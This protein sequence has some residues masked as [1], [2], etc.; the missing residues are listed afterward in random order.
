MLIA[1]PLALEGSG[2]LFEGNSVKKQSRAE[3][4][5]RFPRRRKAAENKTDG[6]Y[7]PLWRTAPRL[8]LVASLR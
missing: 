4:K 2:S 5:S 7:S 1:E 6:I 3:M 8:A